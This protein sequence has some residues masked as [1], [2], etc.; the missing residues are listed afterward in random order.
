MHALVFGVPSCRVCR[1]ARWLKCWH[2]LSLSLTHT[3]SL[4]HSLTHTH[5]LSLSLSLS[6]TH[7]Y[8]LPLSL[9]LTHT[10]THYCI[11]FH[12]YRLA[13][14]IWYVIC[15]CLCLIID[16]HKV[17]ALYVICMCLYVCVYMYVS[18][19]CN[20][21]VCFLYCIWSIFV[22]TRRWTRKLSPAPLFIWPQRFPA[23]PAIPAIPPTQIPNP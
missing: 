10:H 17:S 20:A 1:R 18:A 14:M 11:E 4:S 7:T 3:L 6:L 5:S 19:R 12:T 16:M 13:Y 22:R 8:T 2:S 15:T 9:S 21:Y 23:I